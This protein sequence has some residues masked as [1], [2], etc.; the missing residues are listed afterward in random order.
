MR[1]RTIVFWFIY[2]AVLLA[3]IARP[4]VVGWDPAE[5]LAYGKWM[6]SN[7]GFKAGYRPPIWPL[8]L[9]FLWR[10]GFSMPL[11]MK[12]LAFAIYAFIPLVPFFSFKDSRR[13]VGLLIIAHPIFA[14]YSHLP[15]SHLLA[16]LFFVLAY[17]VPGPASGVFATLSGLTRFTFFLALPFICW[18]DRKKWESA[19]LVLYAYFMFNAVFF[20]NAL[21]PLLAASEVINRPYYLWVWQ[22]HF[23]FYIQTFLI[24]P[25]LL[26]GL[27][28]KSRFSLAS[29]LALSY[30]TLL[31]HK[32]L[33]FVI[34][35]L[36]YLAVALVEKYDRLPLAAAALSFLFLPFYY[37]GFQLPPEAFDVI[38]D[39]ATVVGMTPEVNAYKD[40]YFRPWFDYPKDIPDAEYCIYFDAAVPCNNEEC[41]SKKLQF[42][43]RCEPLYTNDSLNL[44][45][46]ITRRPSGAPR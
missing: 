30:F 17:S 31:P 37:V 18:K 33:R 41:F 12:L 39:G 22:G 10:L 46:G 8:T 19:F 38:P 15:L 36:P 34:D 20:K 21:E 4:M 44:T 25:L 35:F 27:F 11:T 1:R 42:R 9:G 3:F 16:T 28:S 32:E 24:A 2:T 14:G 5:Y 13:Y 29:L 43:D 45:V 23:W 6:F 40:V 7:Y 26:F